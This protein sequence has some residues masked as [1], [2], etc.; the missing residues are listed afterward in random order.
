VRKMESEIENNIGNNDSTE[1]EENGAKF[2]KV[3]F[4]RKQNEMWLRIFLLMILFII[5]FEITFGQISKPNPFLLMWIGFIMLY[6]VIIPFAFIFW[7][8]GVKYK[9]TSALISAIGFTIIPLCALGPL[10]GMMGI[11]EKNGIVIMFLGPLAISSLILWTGIY[12]RFRSNPISIYPT[13]IA[14]A[15]RVTEEY[16]NGYS[17]R[18]LSAK[19]PLIE[20]WV[21]NDFAKFLMKYDL[22]WNL[23]DDPD[24]LT[25]FF[26][27]RTRFTFS[28]NATKSY[29]KIFTQGKAEVYITPEDY[30]FLNV[31]ISYH[32]LCENV[33]GRIRK[34][35]ESFAKGDVAGALEVFRVEK[36]VKK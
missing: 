19:F 5:V 32:V 9:N 24:A 30:N 31:P 28:F 15:E 18:P 17:Q 8:R 27:G 3:D 22:I 10:F 16:M 23:K 14:S 29:C 12:L 20:K 36:V 7:N 26:P 33:V 13:I 1:R 35:Y 11:L 2:T 6:I 34:S 25:L 21:L 4:H